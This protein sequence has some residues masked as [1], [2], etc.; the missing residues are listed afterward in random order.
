LH[1]GEC[2]VV[3]GKYSGF[4]VEFA[5]RIGDEART[6]EIIVSR[7]VKDLVAGSGLVFSDHGSRQFDGVEGD[8]RLYKVVREGADG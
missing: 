6:G 5:E 1:T 3:D 8:W 4:A 2:D 7:T